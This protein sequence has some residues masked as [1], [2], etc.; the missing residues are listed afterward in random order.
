MLV[1]YAEIV[2]KAHA[3][4][5]AVGAFNVL[6]LENVIG[7][8]QAAEELNSPVIL[9]LAECQFPTAPIEYMAPLLLAAAKLAKVP[10]AVH[11]DHGT[12]FEVCHLAAKSGFTGVM[13]DGSHYSLEENLLKTKEVAIMARKFGIGV[14]GELGKV[15]NTGEGPSEGEGD[16]SSADVFTDVDDAAYF[17]KETGIDALAIAIGNLH[18][19][20]AATPKLNVTRMME[21]SKETNLPLV[22]HGGSGTSAEDFKTCAR[23]GICK[24]NVATAIQLRVLAATEAYLK[25]D[26]VSYE[27]LKAITIAA[28]KEVAMEHILL[29]ESNGKADL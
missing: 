11:L 12:S 21:I 15:G 18:G 7:A 26:A 20:Y 22:L 2:Q 28:T 5:Y 16:A 13:F 27:G 9:Q 24:V 8:I 19:K 25:T 14:E 17:V 1:S 6:S 29:F 23:N 10:V 3:N 4:K